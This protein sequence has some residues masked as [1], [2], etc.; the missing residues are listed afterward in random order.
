MVRDSEIFFKIAKFIFLVLT[1]VARPYNYFGH[2]IIKKRPLHVL[3][4]VYLTAN[5]CQS[6]VVQNKS[7]R[8]RSMKVPY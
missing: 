3:E 2:D 5:F 4:F 7:H 6:Y 8:V 1:D